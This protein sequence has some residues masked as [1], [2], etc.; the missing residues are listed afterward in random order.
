MRIFVATLLLYFAIFGLP[1]IGKDVEPQPSPAPRMIT[2]Q[3]PSVEMKEAVSGIAS[4]LRNANDVD[5][6]LW[7][8]VWMKAAKAVASDSEDTKVVWNDTNKL[9]QFTETA[10]RIGWRRIGGNQQGKYAGLNEAV[11]SAFGAILTSRVQPVSPEL[12]RKYVDLCHAI[13]WAGVGRDQ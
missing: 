2:V 5:R 9:R 3:E 1:K 7:G 13:A 4:I 6:M 8:Q 10:L 12:R 11:E